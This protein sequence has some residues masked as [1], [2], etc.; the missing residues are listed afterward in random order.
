MATS[1]ILIVDDHPVMRRGIRELIE[2]VS[3]LEVCADVGTASDAL[4]AVREFHPD[5]A[6]LDMSLPD[7][8]GLEL[9][10]RI[11]A[12]HSDIRVLIVSIHDDELFAERALR[13]GALGYINKSRPG[14]ELL[15]AIRK[16]LGGE[17]VLSP[18]MTQRLIGR[19][20]G[21]APTARGTKSL[22]G[23]EMEIFELIGTGLGVRDI[24]DRLG[25]SP[26][27]VETH[28]DHIR[29]KLNLDS[30]AELAR[31]AA[32]WW[33]RQSQRRDESD[34]DIARPSRC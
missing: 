16:V 5:V 27:T 12:C 32:L 4:S 23:R 20:V 30:A 31:Y 18:T 9:V 17:V 1:K 29:T 8:S 19:A 14:K 33:S 25:V 26:K 24:A 2:D 28:R 11:H 7:G 15:E 6:L 10:K 22:S 3:D 21:G 13:A 34:G